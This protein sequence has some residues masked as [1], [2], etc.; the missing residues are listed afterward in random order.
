MSKI[1]YYHEVLDE[2]FQLPIASIDDAVLEE[3]HK[4]LR[5]PPRYPD[6]TTTIAFEQF[7][8]KKT[9]IEAELYS[10]RNN[11]YNI[12]MTLYSI[13]V[14]FRPDNVKVLDAWQSRTE[15]L[16]LNSR[17]GDITAVLDRN[18]HYG[19]VIRLNQY[20]DTSGNNG[21]SLAEVG[22]E[23]NRSSEEE[24]STQFVRF[25]YNL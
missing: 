20:Y 21:R 17:L 9:E 15:A 3:L 8:P 11:L 7:R 2:Q 4:N 16:F 22:F 19:Y 23:W 12:R 1:K 5:T 13:A 25:L 24:E 14:S 6:D 10:R 18:P